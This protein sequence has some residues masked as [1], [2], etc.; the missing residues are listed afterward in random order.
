M[1]PWLT[2]LLFAPP[3][4]PLLVPAALMLNSLGAA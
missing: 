2:E 4:T 3:H 1:P